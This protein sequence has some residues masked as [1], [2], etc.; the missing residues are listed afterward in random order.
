MVTGYIHLIHRRP[1]SLYKL[2]DLQTHARVIPT[3]IWWWNAQLVA[4]YREERWYVI[5]AVLLLEWSDCAC[6]VLD[7]F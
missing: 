2:L 7:D 5:G 3:H 1:T 4:E 6:L